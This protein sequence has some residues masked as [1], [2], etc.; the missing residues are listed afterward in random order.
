MNS[1]QKKFFRLFLNP[2][3]YLRIRKNHKGK[4]GYI[5]YKGLQEPVMFIKWEWAKPFLY[6]LKNDKHNRYTLNIS[7]VRQEDG[8]TFIK[9]EYKKFKS[10]QHEDKRDKTADKDF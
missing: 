10:K 3:H 5:M 6:F 7:R 1:Y 8:R 2:G 9:K 4:D